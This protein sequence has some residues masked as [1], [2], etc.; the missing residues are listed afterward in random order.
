MNVLEFI[1]QNPILAVII[2]CEVGLWL[3][4]F[5]GLAARYL[6]RLKRTSTVVLASIPL[7]DVV[8][9]VA[10]ALDMA[11]G[12]ELSWV[13]IAAAYYLGVS[14]AFGP[15]LVRYADVRFAHRFAGGPAPEPKPKYGAA[16][17]RAL[18][19]EW[20]RVVLAAAIAS[21]ASLGLIMF[22]A[23]AQA[24][25]MLWRSI[26]QAWFIVGLW[27]AFGPMVKPK[28]DPRP[29]SAHQPDIPA[30]G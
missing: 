6:L 28:D 2:G 8:L 10:V 7:L 1:G 19:Q 13:H 27:Y 12:A 11:R 26:G 29:A 16:K 21:A 23:D 3:L 30:H 25:E 15:S 20:R 4:L 17:H 22:F 18:W 5:L 24:Q 9:L 14:V